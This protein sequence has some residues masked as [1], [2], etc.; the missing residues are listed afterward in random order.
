[1]ERIFWAEEIK[2]IRI[3]LKNHQEPQV[4]PKNLIV[5]NQKKLF[6]I[7]NL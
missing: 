4:G 3:I 1:M 2:Q 6:K 5:K 7:K